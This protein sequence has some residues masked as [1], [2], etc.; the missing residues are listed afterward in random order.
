M[1][2]FSKG[3]GLGAFNY[4]TVDEAITAIPESFNLVNPPLRGKYISSYPMQLER[5]SDMMIDGFYT[6]TAAATPAWLVIR[7]QGKYHLSIV[8]T[9]FI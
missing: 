7:Y 4:S 9:C 2:T 1:L 6:P 3:S 8:Y 5:L